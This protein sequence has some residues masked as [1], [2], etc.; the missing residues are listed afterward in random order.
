[1]TWQRQLYQPN[2]R[3]DT[4]GARPGSLATSL[5]IMVVITNHEGWGRI[6]FGMVMPESIRDFSVDTACWVR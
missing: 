2:L 5:P 4:E 1:M 3:L 6:I